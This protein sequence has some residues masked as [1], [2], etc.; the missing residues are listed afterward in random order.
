MYNNLEK[1]NLD[2]SWLEY[3]EKKPC[4]L[5]TML[6]YEQMRE[7]SRQIVVEQDN[8]ARQLTKDE[9]LLIA[10]CVC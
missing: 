1:L 2:V 5:K 6:D 7:I 9:W 8:L 3:V 4:L 10:R